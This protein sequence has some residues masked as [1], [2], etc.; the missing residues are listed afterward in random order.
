MTNEQKYLRK[1]IK[2]E[3]VI[4]MAIL[5][6]NYLQKHNERLDDNIMQSICDFFDEPVEEEIPTEHTFMPKELEDILL[7]GEGTLKVSKEFMDTLIRE[8]LEKLKDKEKELTDE[9]GYWGGSELQ[10][11]IE[12][13]EELLED[14]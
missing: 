9:Q 8:K 12:K 3:E 6:G 4:H 1:K 11:E 7:N 14:D 13:L 5:L 2:P 10:E